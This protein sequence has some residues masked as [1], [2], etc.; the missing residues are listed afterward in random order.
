[1]TLTKN[2]VRVC[3]L[4]R[5][6][7]SE[8]LAAFIART[9]MEESIQTIAPSKQ[10]S[11]ADM[12]E[13]VQKAV[14]K[15]LRRDSPSLET[16]KMQVEYTAV[17]NRE[18]QL[19]QRATANRQRV[20]A[21]IVKSIITLNPNGPGDFET[22][23]TMYRKI[24]QLL[25][26]YYP[27]D[28]G[29][30]RAVEK[31]VAA[32][33]ESV[34]PRVG[35][36][37]FAEL[38]SPQ[39]EQQL[40]ELCTIVVGIRVFN[41]S[42]GMGGAGVQNINT[43]AVTA[44][45][46]LQDK[47]QDE[48]DGLERLCAAYQNALVKAHRRRRVASR[49]SK[50]APTPEEV[51]ADP[52]LDDE[53]L[54]RWAE[55][56]ANRRQYLAFNQS[57]L[58]QVRAMNAEV[59]DLAEKCDDEIRELTDL[60][61]SQGSVP[62]DQVYPRFDQLAKVW[63]MLFEQLKVVESKQRIQQLLA[64]FKQ[65]FTP[66]LPGAIYS[67]QVPEG[68]TPETVVL[69]DSE[70]VQYGTGRSDPSI[71]L[72]TRRESRSSAHPS[73]GRSSRGPGSSRG[74]GPVR[75]QSGLEV[76]DEF[77]SD[78]E[79]DDF[80]MMEL[81]E[82]IEVLDGAVDHFPAPEPSEGVTLVDIR[83]TPEFAKLPLEFQG[84]C[85]W[86]FVRARGLL[87]LGDPGL[88]IVQ[89]Q[90]SYYVFAHKEGIGQFMQDPEKYLNAIR[91][92]AQAHPEYIQLLSIPEL[93]NFSPVAAHE[94]GDA[95][96]GAATR[97]AGTETPV[98]FVERHIDP[99]YTWNEWELRRRALKLANLQNCATV[100]QQTDASNFRRDNDT[101][102]YLPKDATTQTTRDKG[103]NPIRQFNYVAG[104]RG[105]LAPGKPV[106]RYVSAA[107]EKESKEAFHG[108]PAVVSLKLDL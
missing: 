30:S 106:S 46:T 47:L 39:R 101:Q 59:S 15:L 19:V 34:F 11:A 48:V 103:T 74:S 62:K 73:S 64:K 22:L 72:P 16:I 57:L 51:E 104:L 27:S 85:P 94:P 98:H 43:Q 66:R 55:E 63:M 28:D 90:N 9:V 68:Q 40:H 86:T 79:E 76:N 65:S 105:E 108:R 93:F 17:T 60:L 53:M 7:V 38:G 23:S 56:L 32:A 10:M 36:K 80:G 84:F 75:P 78:T 26:E 96:P 29:S 8:T 45:R 18:E 6:E 83:K 77:I 91:H 50:R 67:E 107:G 3:K 81:G 92:K 95:A 69:A 4:S 88:G 5:V 41:K 24:F 71:P 42:Q 58:Q 99:S 31:E 97:D 33:L 52:A 89:Y 44:V 54:D 14:A 100:S 25:M 87:V 12:D 1:M 21:D 35:I 82:E 20:V 61:S 49:V 13:I 37:A 70:R 102:V 2:I